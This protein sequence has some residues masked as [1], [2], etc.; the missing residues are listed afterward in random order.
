M[1]LSRHITYFKAVHILA[2]SLSLLHILE[3]ISG[4]TNL[5]RKP[6]QILSNWVKELL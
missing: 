6:T 1:I 4:Q 5:T 2:Y 3:N